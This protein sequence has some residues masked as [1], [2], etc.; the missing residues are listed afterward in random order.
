MSVARYQEMYQDYL[1]GYIE[2]RN[3]LMNETE[4]EL[5]T[6]WEIIAEAFL[7]LGYNLGK[8]DIDNLVLSGHPIDLEI[9]IKEAV[10]V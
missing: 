5:G 3:D 2:K 8:Q 1:K 6:G 10:D 9:D 7:V 4:V